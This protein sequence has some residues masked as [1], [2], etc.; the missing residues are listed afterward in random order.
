MSQLVYQISNFSFCYP[1][2]D[3][4][5]SIAGN[6]TIKQG[7]FVLL[8]GNSGHGKSTF[9]KAL[10]GLIPDFINGKFGG[11]ILYNEQDI[12]SLSL[13]SLQE[14]AYLG[15]NP[16]HQIVCK[17]VYLELAFALENQGLPSSFILQKILAFAKQY[18]IEH[19]L[20]RNTGS[21]SGGEKQKICLLALLI[22]RP[23]VLLL[24]EPT[25]FL[26]NISANELIVIIAKYAKNNTVVLIEHN[27]HYFKNIINRHVEIIN[28]S[29]IEHNI[30][31]LP[32]LKLPQIN[33]NNLLQ[34]KILSIKNLSYKYQ[35]K[36]ILNNLN[37]DIFSGDIISI[38][39][40]SGVG[41][42]TLLKLLCKILSVKDMVF[43]N[44]KDIAYIKNKSYWQDVALLWQNPELHFLYETTL[45]EV[46]GDISL[47]QR[48]NLYDVAQNNP[49]NLSEG[50]KRRLSLAIA[51]KK[52]AKLFVL[53]EPTFGQDFNNKLLLL[54]LIKQLS[55]E[56]KSFII[57][58]HD[59]DFVKA[60]SNTIYKLSSG[61][62]SE[63]NAD[64]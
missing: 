19:L 35:T 41:K 52:D 1:F 38:I 16:H 62:L 9:L 10:K 24:D 40:K 4:E 46:D 28:A 44:D 59:L 63:Y 31:N 5:I 20:D 22:T 11:Q 53:D 32:N 18:H 60:I 12:A 43:W 51:L 56:G 3:Q 57:V 54:D 8:S 37:L 36:L 13:S 50:Q 30:A 29:F 64:Y 25:A 15:Q 23:Q 34:C 7:D 45:Q 14:I 2:S 26:D 42:S 21:L 6:L 39:G 61:E 47:L 17:T 33:H 49:F 55:E 27:I 58:S 48:L